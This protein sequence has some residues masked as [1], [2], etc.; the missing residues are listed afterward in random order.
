MGISELVQYWSDEQHLLGLLDRYRSFG[1]LPGVALTFMKSFVPPLP[2]LVIVGVNAA[3]YGLWLGFLYS[4]LG[5]VA[6]CLATFLIVRRIAGH[7][8]LEKYAQRRKVQSGLQWVRRNAF[9]YVFILSIFPVGPFVVVNVAAAIAR[10]RF[11]SFLLAVGAGKAVMVFA[12][13][14]VG[15]DVGRYYR[16]PELL[17]YV[18]LFVVLS[19]VVMKRIERRY[20]RSNDSERDTGLD[21]AG[22]IEAK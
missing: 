11:R 18:V 15:H 14:L 9:S 12:V 17:L 7:P 13:S 8:L 3:V 16:N 2:T 6:G 10:M 21:A 22:E 19:L 20:L 1:P 4:W 5:L